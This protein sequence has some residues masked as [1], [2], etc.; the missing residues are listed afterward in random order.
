MSSYSV[1]Y[2]WYH[3]EFLDT[4]SSSFIPKFHRI[5]FFHSAVFERPLWKPSLLEQAEGVSFL[6][7]RWSQRHIK[8]EPKVEPKVHQGGAC[9]SFLACK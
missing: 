8:V 7:S 4:Q 5:L 6:F 3:L 2:L 1:Y 9:F